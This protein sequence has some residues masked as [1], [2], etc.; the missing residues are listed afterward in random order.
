[1][2]TYLDGLITAR[3]LAKSGKLEALDDLIFE[4]QAQQIETMAVSV[5]VET[6]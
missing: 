2:A 4:I 6:R 1:M 5:E 3:E